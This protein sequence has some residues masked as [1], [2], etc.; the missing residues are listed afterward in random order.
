VTDS[1]VHSTQAGSISVQSASR[2]QGRAARRV[3]RAVLTY[4]LL[5]AVALIFIGPFVLMISASLQPNLQFLTFPIDVVPPHPSLSG[6]SALFSDTPIERWIFNS[7]VVSLSVM[8]LNLI[9]AS[10]GGYAFA[11]GDFPGREV[12]FWVLM[13]FLM[14]PATATLI[15][16]S[17]I[18]VKMGWVDT[19]RAL[20]F[21]GATTVFG[22]FLMRQFMKGIPRDYDDAARIDGCNVFDIY[23]RVILPLCKP[24]LATLA[25]LSFLGI[26][27]DFLY[28]LIVTNS[29]DMRTLTVGLSTLFS[30][31]GGVDIQMAAATVVFSP[32]LIIF[33]LLQKYVVQGFT[34]SGI[35]G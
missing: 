6:Y 34:L 20:I 2:T 29:D 17:V 35:K 21:P 28:P 8:A 14:V 5:T 27:N 31:F 9:T 19:Y 3:L 11:R 30:R 16:L 13:T 23:R 24:A 33:L 32:T 12:I 10:M 18:I 22:T 1:Q 15:P 4:L 26:W 25:M 7:T